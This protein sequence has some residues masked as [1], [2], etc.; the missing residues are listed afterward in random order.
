[1][2]KNCCVCKRKLGFF[3]SGFEIDSRAPGHV[4]C[5]DC[6]TKRLDLRV[7]KSEEDAQT[8]LAHFALLLDDPGTPAPV[9]ESLRRFSNQ[10]LTSMNA[11]MEKKKKKLAMVEGSVHTF[12]TS[13]KALGLEYDTS[14]YVFPDKIRIFRSGRLSGLPEENT[15]YFRDVTSVV[16]GDLNGIAWI[17]FVIPGAGSVIGGR[18]NA[19]AVGG[20]AITLT[21]TVTIPYNDPG[22]IVFARNEEHVAKR[23]YQ[24]IKE[25]YDSFKS[26]EHPQVMTVNAVQQDSAVDKLKKLKE[27]KD[28]G[29]LS[30]EEYEEKRRKLLAEI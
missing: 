25:Y 6:N 13:V 5:G 7:A 28:M 11:Q 26:I 1:M 22:A 29:I 18:Q 21:Q 27:L 14:V 12:D 19:V 16:S 23:E 2:A 17:T 20:G 24:V 3:E 30:D 9:V 15:I 10:G 8:K 4:L